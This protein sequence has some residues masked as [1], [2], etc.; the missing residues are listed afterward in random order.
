MSIDGPEL[1]LKSED[2]HRKNA[3]QMVMRTIDSDEHE[4]WLRDTD[5]TNPQAIFRRLHLKFRGSENVA[6][7]S[8]IEC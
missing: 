7:S 3:A 8:Q 5:P 4:L 6:V 1:D 2:V